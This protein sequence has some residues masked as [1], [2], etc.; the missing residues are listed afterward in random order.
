MNELLSNSPVKRN[1]PSV[2]TFKIFLTS[3]LRFWHSIFLQGRRQNYKVAESVCIGKSLLIK[4]FK[5][6]LL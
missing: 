2:L 5:N 6:I 1:T 4:F 3:S